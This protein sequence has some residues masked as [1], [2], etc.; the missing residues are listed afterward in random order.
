MRKATIGMLACLTAMLVPCT[1]AAANFSAEIDA[2]GSFPG[3]DPEVAFDP[4]G[5]AFVWWTSDT[6]ASIA[7]A[8]HDGAFGTPFRPSDP[9][10]TITRIDLG[11]D[12]AGNA[13]VAWVNDLDQLK[14][15]RR[16]A[17]V[18]GTFGPVQTVASSVEEEWFN[19]DVNPQGAALLSWAEPTPD[20]V[21]ASYSPAGVAT[22]APTFATPGQM[23]VDHNS[24]AA[25]VFPVLD[26]G[27]NPAAAVVWAGDGAPRQATTN[28]ASAPSPFGSPTAM[29]AGPPGPGGLS[30]ASND[31]GNAVAVWRTEPGGG[32]LPPSLAARQPGG[33][34][35]APVPQASDPI[36]AHAA[37]VGANGTGAAVW[38]EQENDPLPP[39]CTPGLLTV[40]LST[41]PFT[42]PAPASEETYNATEPGVA[43]GPDGTVMVGWRASDCTPMNQTR[44]IMARVGAG[45][46]HTFFYAQ[47]STNEA[48][49]FNAAFDSAGNAIAVW[50]R[51]LS[52]EYVK[53]SWYIVGPAPGGGTPPGGDPPGSDPPGGDPPGGD[54]P[55]GD[56]PGGD[57]PGGN[58]P[59]SNDFDLAKRRPTP[60]A[61]SSSR[62]TSLA[63]A[64][65]ARWRP[66]RCPSAQS[67]R[68]RSRQRWR[69]GA[70]RRP[71]QDRS[72]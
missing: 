7:A 29:D 63:P 19:L 61:R 52:T 62:S 27:A 66:G 22:N 9:G 43:V 64:R 30:M 65:S 40:G 72:A 55:G 1:N 51:G 5:N 4:A 18:N 58:A 24:A 53:A 20:K 16:S 69:K 11:F 28:D 31:A 23:L 54:T 71:V 60:M 59:P 70:R 3:S 37:A 32:E 67:P 44:G 49:G 39:S 46:V 36:L 56:P 41:T 68:V 13:V 35:G 15:A 26:P 25:T 10:R 38:Q 8:P 57:P 45:A 47:G 12:S 17:G 48:G 6:F 33:V 42:S 2:S 14:A 34:F 21:W 50:H